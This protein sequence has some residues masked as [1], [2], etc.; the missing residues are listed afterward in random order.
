M[1]WQSA[2]VLA[3]CS[4]TDDQAPN[5]SLTQI[6]LR[7][8]P[9]AHALDRRFNARMTAAARFVSPACFEVHFG[10]MDFPAQL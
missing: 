4:R 9:D 6:G 2:A 8:V 7:P 3:A 5:P 1:R 10:S